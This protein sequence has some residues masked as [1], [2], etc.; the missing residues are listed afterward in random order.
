MISLLFC[1]EEWETRLI[2]VLWKGL[3]IEETGSFHRTHGVCPHW[4]VFQGLGAD[5]QGSN[6]KSV[7]R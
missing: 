2:T 1:L 3:L 7:T 6:F 5:N 4:M